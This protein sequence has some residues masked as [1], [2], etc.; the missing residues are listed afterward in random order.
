MPKRTQTPR[1]YAER[2]YMADKSTGRA[3]TLR[4]CDVIECRVKAFIDGVNWQK[5]Q[6]RA[7]KNREGDRS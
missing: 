2:L 6:A 4:D 5:R 7:G 3:Y 1:Q